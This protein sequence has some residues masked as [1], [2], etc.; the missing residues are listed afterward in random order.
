MAIQ[1]PYPEVAMVYDIDPAQA[2][3]TRQKVADYVAHYHIPIAG[4]HITYPG[5]GYI[6]RN[7]E[8][9]YLFRP[10]NTKDKVQEAVR[11]QLGE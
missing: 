2:V 7:K 5:M 10:I 4:A 11:E 8:G 3:A 1:M 6:V 9:G